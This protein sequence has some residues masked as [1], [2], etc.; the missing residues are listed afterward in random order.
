M[1]QDTT[2]DNGWG[3]NFYPLSPLQQ[4][5]LFH[6]LGGDAPG[7]DIEQVVVTIR[8]PLSLAVFT[9]AWNAVL[10]RHEAL[11]AG[12]AWQRGEP[13]QSFAAPDE[14]NFPIFVRECAGAAEVEKAARDYLAI[15]RKEGFSSLTALLLRGALFRGAE[16]FW[17]FV[18]TYHHL[19]LDARGMIPVFREVFDRHDAEVR[20][21]SL[22]LPAAPRY[23]DFLAWQQ[24]CDLAVSET[25]WRQRL[26]DVTGPTMLPLSAPDDSAETNAPQELVMQCTAVETARLRTVAEKH[27][28][29][30]NTLLQAAWSLVLSRSTGDD[31]VIFGAVRACRHAPVD[32]VADMAGLLINTVPVRVRVADDVPIAAWLRG[33]REQWTALREHEHAPLAKVQQ[34]SGLA[35]GRSLF[36]T[37]INFQE[38]S[39][40]ERLRARGGLW[41][42]RDFEIYGQPNYPL[43][44]DASAGETLRIRACFDGRRFTAEP[45]SRLLGHLSVVLGALAAEQAATIG[46]LPWMTEQETRQVL[47]AWNRTAAEYRRN[48]CV[49]QFFEAHA[50]A[51][52]ERVAVG[53]GRETLT[54][55]ELNGRANQLAHR[56]A[57]L[58][59]GPDVRVAVCMERSIEMFVAWLAVLKAGGAFVPLDPAYPQERLAFQ[60]ADCGARVW[61][62]QPAVAAALPPAPA[63]DRVVAAGPWFRERVVRQS[64]RD[65]DGAKYRLRHLHVR[66]NRPAQGRRD[67]APVVDESGDVAPGNV[68][69][70]RGGPR[71]ANGE[72]GVRRRGLG[73]L[74][75]SDQR[76]ER[77]YHR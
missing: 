24:T 64:R 60:L 9:R 46:G 30:L 23:R 58:G 62:T 70:H 1:V 61:L 12:F 59:V 21:E 71:D 54:Y 28:V 39:W 66:L 48:T 57:S 67:R 10:Q 41:A 38:P 6:R 75:V 33:I 18:L 7:V 17:I 37:I 4:G 44:I 47:V 63:G 15:D 69:R 11:R 76:S 73:G 68:W 42:Q 13:V 8:H 14:V 22:G 45:I 29:T 43:A 50:E 40:D 55:R 51:A 52:P 72:P 31:D 53:D 3:D 19:V 32:G 5:M 26:Q 49:H 25:F 27:D 36:D 56:L 2:V 77:A 20:G 65:R 34:W 35:T 16:D 74:A